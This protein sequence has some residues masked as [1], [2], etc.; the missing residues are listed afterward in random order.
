MLVFYYLLLTCPLLLSQKSL[1]FPR[2][3]RGTYVGIQPSY[4]FRQQ[5]TDFQ[6]AELTI[7]ITVDK[8]SVSLCFP[9][10]NYCSVEQSTQVYFQKS[11]QNG[12]K[13][14]IFQVNVVD[15]AL[16]EEW[17]LDSK[18]KSFLRKGI[19][20]QPDTVLEKLGKKQ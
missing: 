2:K 16:K 14:W 6:F 20:P 17:V 4:A 10:E 1:T 5:G 18:K 19:R 11:K 9:K 12:R 3:I 13:L 15:A 8:G 7:K